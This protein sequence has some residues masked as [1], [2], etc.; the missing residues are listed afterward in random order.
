MGSISTGH[1]MRV[2][3]YLFAREAICETIYHEIARDCYV[4]G[5]SIQIRIADD[6]ITISNSC[7]LPDGWTVETLME[8]H[9]SKPYNPDTANI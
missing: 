9:D 2:E 7:I 6:S 5:A 3:E 4:Y 1:D 8:P